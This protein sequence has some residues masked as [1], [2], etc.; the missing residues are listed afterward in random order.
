MAVLQ[1]LECLVMI[2]NREAAE[3]IKKQAKP[4]YPHAST[5]NKG[6]RQHPPKFMII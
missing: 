4:S 2:L 1:D 5:D 3:N 6:T